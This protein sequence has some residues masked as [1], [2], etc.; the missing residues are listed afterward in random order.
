MDDSVKLVS[1]FL[2]KFWN[3]VIVSHNEELSTTCEMYEE[4]RDELDDFA[5]IETSSWFT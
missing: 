4:Y 3:S 5:A 2:M 1:G